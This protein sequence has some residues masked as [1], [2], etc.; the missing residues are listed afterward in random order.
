MDFAQN[1]IWAF[2]MPIHNAIYTAAFPRKFCPLGT[3][4]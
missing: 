3:Y 1:M 2:F 4:V